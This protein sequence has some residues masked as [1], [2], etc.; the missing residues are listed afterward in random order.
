MGAA[1]AYYS[2][3]EYEISVP[4]TDS[5][6]YDLLI[7]KS[8]TV[9]KVQCKTT[10]YKTKYGSFQV[11]LATAGGNQS[12]TTKKNMDFSII[13]WIFILTSD[14]R[15]YNIPTFELSHLAGGALTLGKKYDKFLVNGKVKR[16]YEEVHRKIVKRPINRKERHKIDWPSHEELQQLVKAI[17]YSAT[18][19]K[20]GVSDNAIRKHLHTKL[21]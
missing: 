1:I 13:D 6:Y 15:W 12:F 8:G 18:G 2:Q 19:R 16:L 21:E 7:E 20:L 10:R 11:Q 5:T 3:E 9:E 4:L 14:G 17:G